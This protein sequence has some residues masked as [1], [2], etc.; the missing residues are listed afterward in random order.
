MV[1][2]FVFKVTYAVVVSEARVSDLSSRACGRSRGGSS[3]TWGQGTDGKGQPSSAPPE[4]ALGAWGEAHCFSVRGLGKSE[5]F[6][7]LAFVVNLIGITGNDLAVAQSAH[8]KTLTPEN[9]P[10]QE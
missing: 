10:R 5:V 8:G 9:W 2:V 6:L 1:P 3:R 4:G 7:K